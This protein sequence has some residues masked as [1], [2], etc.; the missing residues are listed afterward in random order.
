VIDAEAYAALIC[1]WC[2]E[3]QPD[4]QILVQTTTVAQEPALAL[5]N[6]ILE[7]GGWPF[8]RLSLPGQAA[9]FFAHARD[10]QLDR[11]PPLDLT[12]MEAID[13]FLRIGAPAGRHELED[14]EP[15]LLSRLRRAGQPVHEARLKRRW[16]LSIWPTPALAEE[17][18]MT[19][20]EYDGFLERALFLDQRDPVA[21]WQGLRD[22]QQLLVE[23]LRSAERIRIE[24]D[25][26][27]LTLS[28][29]GRI[30][31]NSDGRR[32]MPSGEV[33]TSPLERS[34]NGTI[35]F[36]IPSGK[37]AVEVEGVDVSFTDGEITAAH[38]RTGDDYLQAQIGT[39]A[40]A[41]FLGEIGIGTNTG[42]DR[43]T[44]STLLDEKIAGTVH[45]ALGA[46]YP[47]CGGQNHS[48][49]HWDLICDLRK[50]GRITVDGEALSVDGRFVDGA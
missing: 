33:F 30:W 31:R 8:L 16:A 49:I 12:E 35:H 17:A 32:N 25:R 2:L 19:L 26:T 18:R 44:G 36:D 41:R 6:A 23:R 40:G 45:L 14:V 39:D 47:E 3:V 42:I 15:A 38:A 46:S 11:H 29:A 4:Q 43:A 21:A 13:A 28:V 37:D 20:P 5:H 1:D 24:S 9:A 50:G 10:G 27:D 34:A 48:A 7:R 22:R